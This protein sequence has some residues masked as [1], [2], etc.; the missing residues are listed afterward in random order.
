MSIENGAFSRHA[1][2]QRCRTL[3]RR[4][5]PGLPP[6]GSSAHEFAWQCR[7]LAE[8]VQTY[9]ELLNDNPD[10]LQGRH[11]EF[12]LQ[13]LEAALGA[14]LEYFRRVYLDVRAPE[15]DEDPVPALRSER[16][17]VSERGMQ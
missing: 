6:E 12:R 9:D 13:R 11:L 7:A 1:L 15:A 17:R 8:R 16:S 5:R 3:M 14:S 10:H 2:L 4:V